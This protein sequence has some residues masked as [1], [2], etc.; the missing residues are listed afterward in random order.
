MGVSHLEIACIM[1]VEIGTEIVISGY[2]GKITKILN[3]RVE[4]EIIEGAQIGRIV[5]ISLEQAER[6]V[7]LKYE[8]Y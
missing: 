1:L 3:D 8:Y 4:V 6:A 2:L 5:E 7:G